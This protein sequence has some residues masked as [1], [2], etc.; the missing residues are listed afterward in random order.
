MIQVGKEYQNRTGR[1]VVLGIQGN[2]LRVRFQDGTEGTLNAAMQERIIANM[3]REIVVNP[4][5]GR[6]ASSQSSK[7][8]PSGR[9]RSEGGKRR[10]VPPTAG[11]WSR[12]DLW[13]TAIFE[14]FFNA[15]MSNQLVYIDVDESVLETLA[16]DDDAKR[17]PE[18]DF[19]QAVKDTLG[20]LGTK[21]LLSHIVRMHAWKAEGAQKAPPFLGLLASFC[22]AA[23]KMQSDGGISSSNYYVRLA[24]QFL[25][26]S[27]QPDQKQGL[28]R[29]FRRARDLWEALDAWLWENGGRLGLPSAQPMSGLA[30]VGY[31]ISQSLLR[32][33][34]RLKLVEFFW[35]SSLDPGQQVSPLDLERL[36]DYWILRSNLSS[37]AK[38]R[39]SNRS[40]RRKMAEIASL[41]LSTWNGMLPDKESLPESVVT[42][43][44]ALQVMVVGGPRPR[45]GWDVVLR[46]PANLV[47]I[48]YDAVSDEL[49]L[50]FT[51]EPS[52]SVTVAH[53][54]SNRWS[55]PIPNVSIGD[56]LVSQVELADQEGR[57]RVRWAATKGIGLGVGR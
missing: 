5:G 15:Q 4:H 57:N 25:G 21:Y 14:S 42:A 11:S 35:N 56:L 40:A 49:G 46:V 3:A 24:R 20:P 9:P 18:Q 30:H 26:P 6:Y 41:E 55:D 48:T 32:A 43:P 23:Q 16:P 27:F 45:L 13:N 12:Y 38:T 29:G 51:G 2:V 52:R 53:G 37:V 54:L 44:I 10:P 34:D 31:P 39:W 1:Y 50:P 7:K 17:S 28:Q 8:P 47:E 19:V 22:L 36:L 33:Q